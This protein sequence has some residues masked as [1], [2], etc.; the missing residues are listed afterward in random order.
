MENQND[1]DNELLNL[2]QKAE[3]QLSSKVPVP[4]LSEAETQKLLHE[5]QVHQIELKMQNEELRLAKNHLEEAVQKYAVLYDFAPVGYFS[6][7]RTGEI[8][9]LNFNGAQKLGKDRSSLINS[10]FRFFLSNDS[11]PAFNVFLGNV[12]QSKVKELCEVIL[13]VDG[14]E[15]MYVQLNGIATDSGEQ[16]LLTAID[17]TESKHTEETLRKSEVRFR[18]LLQDVQSVSVQGY[19][20][21]GTTQYW[22]QASERLYGYTAEEAIGKNLVDLII[23]PEM[24]S[25]VKQAIRQMAGTGQ[26]IPSSELSLMHKDGSTV[27]VFSSHTIIQVSGQAQELFCI[28]IDLTERKKA[29]QALKE[30]EEKYRFMFANNPQPMWIF[31]LETLAFLEVNQAAVNHYGYSSDEFLTMTLKDIR[32]IEDIPEL[33]KN[34][35]P[36]TLEYNQIGEFRHIKKN[37]E[38]IHVQITWHNVTFNGRKAR[39][40]LI[41]DVTARNRVEKALLSRKQQ[42]DDLVSKIPVGVYIL[43]SKPDGAF[44]LDYA[45]PRMAEMLNLSVESLLAENET[46]FKAIH[47]DDVDGFRKLSQDGVFQHRPFNWEGRIVA[48]GNLKWMHFRSTPELLE[49][50]DTLWH[51][52][53]VDIT[54]RVNAEQEISLKNEELSNLVAEKDRFF[55]IIAHDLRSPFNAILGYTQMLEEDLPI[56][57]FDQIKHISSVLRN[58]A[59]NAY[60]LLENLLE[61]SRI[62]RGH[63]SYNPQTF[64]LI[65]QI[66]ESLK[67][68]IELARKKWIDISVVVP[69][70]L[71]VLADQNML[72]SIIRNLASNAIKFT[73]KFGTVMFSA[74][75]NDDQ[76]IEISVKDSG[77]GMNKSIL[78]K[79]FSIDHSSNRRGTDG[80]SSSVWV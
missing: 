77:I 55:S 35:E 17:I 16:C 12:F 32:P 21:D 46:I 20:P 34:V 45:S 24:R 40:V 27:S 19:A 60:S 37:G 61:W 28:D 67:S 42:Y 57:K 71:Q 78:E 1:S 79:L 14:N 62:K 9:R 18:K 47:P 69:E 73:P 10:N 39:H 52:L 53:I 6:L 26:P 23:P 59:F 7:S 56:M 11:L 30:S 49:N 5:L 29:E 15:P 41:N 22:N 76:N 44:A 58:S 33:L 64:S 80:E 36:T 4:P 13:S 25:D 66:E 31:D 72:G 48:D 54:D 38:M 68:V 2:R 51:G 63:T 70:D 3:M 50:G 8:I 65:S 74:R 75:I 43:R